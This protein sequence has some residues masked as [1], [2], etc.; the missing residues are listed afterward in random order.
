MFLLRSLPAELS[1]IVSLTM[2][3]HPDSD[4][5]LWVLV[6]VFLYGFSR[7]SQASKYLL[8]PCHL[9]SMFVLSGVYVCVYVCGCDK[10]VRVPFLVLCLRYVV[11]SAAG[12]P[13]VGVSG[14]VSLHLHLWVFAVCLPVCA[15]VGVYQ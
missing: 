15:F 14:R 11:V 10:G 3:L 7:G 1:S 9:R 2:C 4:G 8:L 12:C 5:Q 6:P 13:F